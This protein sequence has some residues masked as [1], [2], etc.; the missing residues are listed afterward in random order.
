MRLGSLARGNQ[1]ET[2]PEHQK[3]TFIQ[4]VRAKLAR[5]V[6]VLDEDVQQDNHHDKHANCG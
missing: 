4:R 3:G 6:K 5:V 1:L 2:V